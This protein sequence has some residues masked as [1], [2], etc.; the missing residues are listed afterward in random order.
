MKLKIENRKIADNC[1]FIAYSLLILICF[2]GIIILADM[3]FRWD[4]LSG[5]IQRLAYLIIFGSIIIIISTF[6]ISFMVNL[7]II[8]NSLEDISDNLRQNT[9]NEKIN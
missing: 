8:S 3:I 9:Q 7:N 4:I 1:T 6:L 5:N 2:F